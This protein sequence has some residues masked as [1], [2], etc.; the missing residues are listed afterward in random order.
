MN[1][2]AGWPAGRL[3]GWPAG[4]VVGGL[5]S[6]R[7]NADLYRFFFNRNMYFKEVLSTF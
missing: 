1:W 2:P 7:E 3:A 4:W 5:A 6:R